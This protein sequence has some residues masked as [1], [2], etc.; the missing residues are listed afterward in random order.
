MKKAQS[1]SLST[2]VIAA[3]VLLILVLIATFVLK[4]FVG[5]EVGT[6]CE[7]QS[8][9][10]CSELNPSCDPTQDYNMDDDKTYIKG[11]GNCGTDETCCIVLGN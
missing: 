10:V 3:L 11:S 9:G 2:I 8:S 4:A 6:S 7:S 5:V 1:L